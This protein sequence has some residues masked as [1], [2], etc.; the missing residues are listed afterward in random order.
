[1]A[2]RE[3]RRLAKKDNSTLTMEEGFHVVNCALEAQ[4]LKQTGASKYIYENFG[5]ASGLMMIAARSVTEKH[6][7]IYALA[8]EAPL[9]DEEIARDEVL[10]PQEQPAANRLRAYFTALT[11]SVSR[12]IVRRLNRGESLD[13]VTASIDVMVQRSNSDLEPILT[14]IIA[15]GYIAGGSNFTQI[16]SI[17]AQIGLSFNL[18]NQQAVDYVRSETERTVAQISRTTHRILDDIVRDGVEEGLSA[19]EIARRIRGLDG[20]DNHLFGRDVNGRDRA[21]RI[22]ARELNHRYSEGLLA[23]GQQYDDEE[24]LRTE[25][26]WRDSNDQRVRPLHKSLGATGWVPIDQVYAGGIIPGSEP[27]CR[28]YL[29]IRVVVDDE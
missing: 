24:G 21:D 22:A 5:G 26:R 18:L 25:K 11:L 28:C 1:M 16:A 6:E 12:S 15:G 2:S 14:D 23:V 7:E 8:M 9:S 27:G 3:L 29:Q 4:R 20:Y 13:Q 10:D 17:P 19:S